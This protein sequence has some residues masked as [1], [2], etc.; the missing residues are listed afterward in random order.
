MPVPRRGTRLQHA[1]THT[2][3]ACCQQDEAE[4]R[5]VRGQD[6]LCF[7]SVADA[8]LQ[9]TLQSGTVQSNGRITPTAT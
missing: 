8:E 3:D 4:F 9:C 5:M 6:P 1:A 2:Q 7:V